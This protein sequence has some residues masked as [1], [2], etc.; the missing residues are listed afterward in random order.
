MGHRKTLATKSELDDALQGWAG[1]SKLLR[2][3][4]AVWLLGAPMQKSLEGILQALLHS[5][6]LEL[7]FSGGSDA[8]QMIKQ[9]CQDPRTSSSKLRNWS[10]GTLKQMLR[11]MASLPG[12]KIFFLI[13]ALDECEPQDRLGELAAEILW[14]SQL[15]NVKVCVS[16][17]PWTQFTRPF[18]EAPILHLDRLTYHDMATYIEHRLMSAEADHDLASD[19]RGGSTSAKELIYSVADAASGVFLWVELALKEL[20]SKTRKGRTVREL[21]QSATSF[22]TNLDDYFRH[23]I[24]ERIGKTRENALETAA[25]LKLAMTVHTYKH[26]GINR[27]HPLFQ[28]SFF[29]FWLLKEGRLEKGF[30]WAKH[31][32]RSYSTLDINRM[33]RETRAFL[34]ETCNDL[35]VFNERESTVDYFHRSVFDFLAGS[36]ISNFIE[37]D[38]PAHFQDRFF[39]VELAMLRAIC[40]LRQED[41]HVRDCATRD[42]M[43]EILTVTYLTTD[44]QYDHSR[45]LATCDD[46]IASAVRRDCHCHGLDHFTHGGAVRYCAAVGLYRCLLEHFKGMPHR[47]LQ[48]AHM[49]FDLNLLGSLLQVPVDVGAQRLESS[50]HVMALLHC[51]LD[52]GCDP[53]GSLGYLSRGHFL[54]YWHRGEVQ[55]S[56]WCK[57]TTW[58]S[59]LSGLYLQSRNG[60]GKLDMTDEARQHQHDIYSIACLLLQYGADP[61]CTP[62]IVDHGRHPYQK[63]DR[64][65]QRITLIQVLEP[66]LREDDLSRLQS[67]YST[68]SNS[69]SPYDL[70]RNQYRRSM[71]SLVLSERKF[72]SRMAAAQCDSSAEQDLWSS[73][74]KYE[75]SDF[76]QGL[77][78]HP[79]LTAT[80][81]YFCSQPE[82][83]VTLV[84]WCVDCQEYSYLCLHC[85][86]TYPASICDLEP[87]C[88][89]P[90]QD[91]A[92]QTEEHTSIT[93]RWKQ[94]RTGNETNLGLVAECTE[95]QV[96]DE[97]SRPR[98]SE[99][100]RYGAGQ[101]IAVLKDWYA[102]NPMDT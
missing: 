34:A 16:C 45:W 92:A 6:L 83:A 14:I 10:C 95:C 48:T 88:K 93:V 23:L 25:V 20:C 9:V 63:N 28:K 29:D 44:R 87:P 49:S 69:C 71:R 79:N 1:G 19:F 102:R 74:N 12:V 46:L 76:V 85:S 62:C 52:Y 32:E 84:S 24:F 75:V 3:E 90:V 57:R 47:V 31:E 56:M 100:L 21:R 17:R 65:C 51:A 101:A 8:I 67:V 78:G 38:A 42:F 2:A 96:S 33:K 86:H 73:W 70:R 82:N 89:K 77:I 59:W 13:D 15:P 97:Y 26:K 94:P 36:T 54:E 53:N 64:D 40:M 61:H 72:A 81:C 58:E 39:V 98:L 99:D 55:F 7:S 27:W 91:H 35:L 18:K 30:S 68:I 11:R 22:P 37:Q 80:A 5:A 60:I 66:V 50:S 41:L 4:H 43:M